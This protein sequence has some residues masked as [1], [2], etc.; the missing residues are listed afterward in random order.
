[1]I[2][3][4][5]YKNTGRGYILVA[6]SDGFAGTRGSNLLISKGRHDNSIRSEIYARFVTEDGVALLYTGLDPDGVRGSYI[7]H[8]ILVSGQDTEEFTGFADIND[9]IFLHKYAS[10]APTLK[11]LRVEDVFSGDVL[12]RACAVAGEVFG[13]NVGLLSDFLESLFCF[14]GIAGGYYGICISTGIDNASVKLFHFF[15]G[16]LRLCGSERAAKLGYRSL[17]S[18]FDDNGTFPLFGTH[19]TVE[20][21]RGSDAFRF[22]VVIDTRNVEII[23]P[24]SVK[25]RRLSCY[26]SLAEKML[27]RD[28]IGVQKVSA[29]VRREACYSLNESSEKKLLLMEK[30]A[31][32]EETESA[33]V[34][35]RSV[36]MPFIPEEIFP[37][38][39]EHRTTG[40]QID[41]IPEEVD[42]VRAEDLST[43]T[44]SAPEETEPVRTQDRSTEGS[45][46]TKEILESRSERRT[47]S[48]QKD[49]IPKETQ[50]ER[51]KERL[52]GK[53][54][55]IHEDRLSKKQQKAPMPRGLTPALKACLKKHSTHGEELQRFWDS[56]YRGLSGKGDEEFRALLEVFEKNELNSG[57]RYY[58]ALVSSVLYVVEQRFTNWAI[59]I[60]QKKVDKTVK[61]LCSVFEKY[62]AF[63][64]ESVNKIGVLYC[65]RQYV[66]SE[67]DDI[68]GLQE[69]ILL[70]MERIGNRN[71]LQETFDAL[72][73]S[74]CRAVF[75]HSNSAETLKK[76]AALAGLLADYRYIKGEK[77]TAHWEKA[78]Q[79]KKKNS[80]WRRAE[81]YGG[82]KL[83]RICMPSKTKDSISDVYKRFRKLA[84]QLVKFEAEER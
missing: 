68:D 69:T 50:P 82:G 10:D 58:D 37:N 38:R 26:Q 32:A 8:Q 62:D 74:A 57:Y 83:Y 73:T 60:D 61:K 79:R 56:R 52:T 53:P 47:A 75:L 15:E 18:S 13:K 25:F 49:A 77:I 45:S 23:L 43:G 29:Q 20:A 3:Q 11:P 51:A 81:R 34:Q 63:N 33:R 84:G 12:D 44:P 48:E 28:T 54:S 59:A 1:M 72:L 17:W 31:I 36:D 65:I 21:L 4:Q 22:Y 14:C 16:L 40:T 76:A 64:E 70:L 67:I 46:E 5:I 41:A 9:G 35:N 24:A 2:Q 42:S 80:F 30:T 6:Q 71:F 78:L 66:G 7:S 19:S 27:N 55:N 39:S